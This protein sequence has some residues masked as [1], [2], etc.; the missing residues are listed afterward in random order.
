MEEINL[1]RKEVI[2]NKKNQN[3]GYIYINTPP[4]YMTISIGITVIVILVALFFIFAEF[5]EKF[6]VLGYLNSTEAV[7][8]VYPKTK[9][10]II[11][12]YFHNEDKVRKGDKLF[13]I[14][15]SY[16]GI[17]KKEDNKIFKFLEKRKISIENEIKYKTQYLYELEKLLQKNIYH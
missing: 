7:V 11:K 8:N 16:I 2:E 14:D 10:I 13:L 9:G 1:F 4:K 6:N 5:S 15:T 17:H 3:H 12:S